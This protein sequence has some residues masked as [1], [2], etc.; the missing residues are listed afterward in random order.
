MIQIL[1][2]A[3]ALLTWEPGG[4]TNLLSKYVVYHSR[5]ITGPFTNLVETVQTNATLPKLASGTHFFF[6]TA[7]GTNGFESDPSNQVFAPVVAP[8]Q[9]AKIVITIP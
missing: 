8:P 3:A 2:F 5:I 7:V 4:P 9:G 1:A 6:V